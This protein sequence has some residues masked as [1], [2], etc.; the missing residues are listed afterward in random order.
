[1]E[2]RDEGPVKVPRSKLGMWSV[3]LAL[4]FGI[5]FWIFLPRIGRGL[6]SLT[7]PQRRLLCSVYLC[8]SLGMCVLGLVLARVGLTAHGRDRRYCR[9]G[10]WLNAAL[11]VP[12]SFLALALLSGRKPTYAI[13]PD[14]RSKGVT[15]VHFEMFYLDKF[16]DGPGDIEFTVDDPHEVRQL[17]QEIR[18]R[19]SS[20][21]KCPEHSRARFIK[22]NEVTEVSFCSHC[23][24]IE[25]PAGTCEYNKVHRV[26]Y[27]LVQE[28]EERERL[29]QAASARASSPPLPPL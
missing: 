7:L 3:V 17:T 1:M 22:G 11:L 10:F 5:G 6:G 28:Y 24:D 27:Q 15:E 19:R 20:E 16:G 21:C 13:A 14:E 29:R 4:L 18:L 23:F 26:F 9:L 25:T 12:L 8:V 2:E